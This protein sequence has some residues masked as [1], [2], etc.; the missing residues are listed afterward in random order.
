MRREECAAKAEKNAGGK[1]QEQEEEVWTEQ[2]RDGG[3]SLIL[4]L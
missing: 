2:Q 4:M 1:H 3:C